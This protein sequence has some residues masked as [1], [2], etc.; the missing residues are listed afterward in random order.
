MLVAVVVLLESWSD[1]FCRSVLILNTIVKQIMHIHLKHNTVTHFLFQKCI[2][3]YIY[4]NVGTH[5][6]NTLSKY[7]PKPHP[8][9]VSTPFSSVAGKTQTRNQT[10]NTYTH[11]HRQQVNTVSRDST[12]TTTRCNQRVEHFAEIGLQDESN[13][14]HG[15]CMPAYVACRTVWMHRAFLLK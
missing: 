6:A 11:V 14:V 13:I 5:C 7:V 2:Y 10:Q 12:P 8:P 15:V 1:N 4:V 9:N 3:I